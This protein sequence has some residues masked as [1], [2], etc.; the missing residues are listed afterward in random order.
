MTATNEAVRTLYKALLDAWNRRD[1]TGMA[2]L[3]GATGN[4][5][6]F[7]GTTA[8][9]ADEIEAHLTEVF[10]RHPTAKFVAKVREVREIGD[11]AALLRAVAG[12][13]PP[14]EDDINSETNAIQTLV[15]SRDGTGHWRIELFQNTPAAFDGRTDEREKLSTELRGVLAAPTSAMSLQGASHP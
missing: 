14:G 7:D 3:Y 10:A 11:G 13:V 8:N 15:A 2:T 4:Q 5:V 1:A 6:G 12:M 9:G